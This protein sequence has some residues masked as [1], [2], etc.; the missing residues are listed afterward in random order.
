MEWEEVL[1]ALLLR[2]DLVQFQ[3]PLLPGGEL[4]GAVWSRGLRVLVGRI[5]E[6][7]LQSQLLHQ[8]VVR[9]WV[10]G[11]VPDETLHEFLL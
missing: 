6:Y 8:L 2:R 10:A 11:Q 7:G 5:Q 1:V 4:V 9:L 3:L